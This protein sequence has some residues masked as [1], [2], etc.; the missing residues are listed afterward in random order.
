MVDQC[1]Q[2]AI[3]IL[4]IA[5]AFHQLNAQHPRLFPQA[6]NRIDLTIVSKQAER[7]DTF[8]AG[9]SVR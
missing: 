5:S 8:E 4:R 7:L 6:G 2:E 9:G 1:C 3:Q